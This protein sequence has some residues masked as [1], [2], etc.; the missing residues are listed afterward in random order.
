M[1][2]QLVGALVILSVVLG[3][4]LQKRDPVE[5]NEAPRK[6]MALLLPRRPQSTQNTIAAPDSA[7]SSSHRMSEA[8]LLADPCDWMKGISSPNSPE[9]FGL[10]L[11]SFSQFLSAND[12][13]TLQWLYQVPSETEPSQPAVSD[14]PAHHVDLLFLQAIEKGGLLMGRGQPA[15]VKPA[16]AIALLTQA[17]EMDSQNAAVDLFLAY[18][19]SQMGQNDAAREALKAGLQKERFD[20]Y[21]PRVGK[22]LLAAPTTPVGFVKAAGYFSTMP[23]PDLS[24]IREA[25][26]TLGHV[27]ELSPQI[28]QFAERVANET[29]NSRTPYN[30]L[31]WWLSSY[32]MA[33]SILR[34]QGQ[35]YPSP[36]EL[37]QEYGLFPEIPNMNMGESCDSQRL[38]RQIQSFQSF[39]RP[40]VSR[41]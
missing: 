3:L 28:F 15:Q 23:V 24:P 9:E 14:A 26:M 2:R 10:L 16:R 30:H 40:Q 19:L 38:S 36:F 37:Y 27:E 12:R 20:V 8:E 31:D 41:L 22:A 6:E 35:S 17:Q 33:T 29:M 1:E 32:V 13:E 39:I 21:L 34:Q 4:L 5:K 18:F 25:L 11:K 7:Q